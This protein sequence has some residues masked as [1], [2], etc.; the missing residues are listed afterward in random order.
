MNEC[1]I[2]IEGGTWIIPKCHIL[3][4]NPTINKQGIKVVYKES[5]QEGRNRGFD[6]SLKNLFIKSLPAHGILELIF[7]VGCKFW[8]LLFPLLKL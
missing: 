3:N 8:D 2:S 1:N 6:P 5:L 4:Q 7:K